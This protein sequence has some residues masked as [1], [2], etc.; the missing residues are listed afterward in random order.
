MVK[1]WKR[2]KSR[3]RPEANVSR[4]F[5]AGAATGL[6]LSVLGLASVS[7][8][9]APPADRSQAPAAP[10]PAPVAEVAPAPEAPAPAAPAAAEPAPAPANAP[11]SAPAPEP[12]AS[13][14]APEAPAQA[15]ETE[16]Q[17][18]AAPAPAAPAATTEPAPPTAPAPAAP[19]PAEPATSAA[20]PPPAAATAAES[21]AALPA[22]DQAPATAPAPVPAEAPAPAETAAAA[23]A[24]TPPAM[25]QTAPAPDP[26]AAAPAVEPAPAAAPV[27]EAVPPVGRVV[28]QP[29]AESPDPSLSVVAGAGVDAPAPATPPPAPATEPTPEA[30]TTDTQAAPETGS[31]TPSILTP[32]GTGKLS[33]GAPL[34]SG[35]LVLK[36]AAAADPP[37]SLPKVVTLVPPAGSAP[38]QPATGP[39]P[40]DGAAPA[41]PDAAAKPE[42]AA[43][44]RVVP[45]VTILRMPGM[46]TAAPPGTGPDKGAQSTAE[47]GALKRYAASFT[48]PDNKPLLGI[49]IFDDGVAA[50]G[51][52]PAAL[53][54]LPFPVTIAVDPERPDAS[55]VAASYHAAGAEVAIL[56]GDLPDGST[57]SDVEVAYQSF[58]AALPDSVALVGRPGSAMVKG[59]LAADHVTALLADDGRGLI[60]Y[61]AGLNDGRRAAQKA[62]VPNAVI[63]K[64]LSASDDNSGTVGRELDRAAF[65]AAQKGASVVALPSTPEAV[66]SLVAWATG[67]SAKSVAVAPVSAVMMT[68]GK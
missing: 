19:A 3:D 36:P 64:L 65:M 51:L 17:V 41:G 44:G 53:A 47:A 1:G 21:P 46:A 18:A 27:A 4:S 34:P 5:I 16:T 35:P 22:A 32:S 67:P 15:P 57:A 10:A 8:M 39:A 62:G 63:E 28:T 56:A 23:P 20:A 6:A 66:T 60:T 49:L 14:P 59:G 42:G 58:T 31:T 2:T 24:A 13:V 48:N 26:A 50:G 37:A 68:K 40:A 61:D 25:P 29:S 55:A 38:D 9:V 12:T 33:V 30:S 11:A 54:S 52:D 7:L 45:G 43:P